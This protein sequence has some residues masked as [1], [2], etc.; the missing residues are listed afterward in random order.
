MNERLLGELSNEYFD[1]WTGDFL[2]VVNG[3]FWAECDYWDL[4]GAWVG[5]G[6]L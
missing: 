5:G 3:G 1:A 6:P 2:E 4:F